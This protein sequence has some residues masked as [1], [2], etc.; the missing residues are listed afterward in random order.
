M[1]ADTRGRPLPQV[2]YSASLLLYL[3]FFMALVIKN[4]I[5]ITATPRADGT[6]NAAVRAPPADF[7]SSSPPPRR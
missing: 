7:S 2:A 4:G 5:S 6:F 3:F 1:R